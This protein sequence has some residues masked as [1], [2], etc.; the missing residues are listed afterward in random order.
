VDGKE[1][2]YCLVGRTLPLKITSKFTSDIEKFTSD[3]D[4]TADF[5][6]ARHRSDLTQSDALLNATPDEVPRSFKSIE[7]TAHLSLIG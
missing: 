1:R 7:T 3:V 4:A 6:P 2:A 5:K